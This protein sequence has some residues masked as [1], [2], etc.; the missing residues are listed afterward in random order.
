M[1]LSQC[2]HTASLDAFNDH[3][4][5]NSSPTFVSLF[6]CGCSTAD[7]AVAEVSHYWNVPQVC[8]RGRSSYN[9]CCLYVWCRLDC[10][11]CKDYKLYDCAFNN[12]YYFQFPT[13]YHNFVNEVHTWGYVSCLEFPPDYLIYI[14]DCICKISHD[15]AGFK[16]ELSYC[17]SKYKLWYGI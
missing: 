7:I 8:E 4:R 13:R 14:C 9:V 5:G 17:I 6:C 1:C 16:I 12:G 15:V 2:D 3:F 10:F 11:P